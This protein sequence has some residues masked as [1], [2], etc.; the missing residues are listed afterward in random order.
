MERR[1]EGRGEARAGL[2][3]LGLIMQL[4]G[5]IM[6]A[7]LITRALEPLL[8]R[9]FERGGSIH[10]GDLFRRSYYLE[11]RVRGRGEPWPPAWHLTLLASIAILRALLHRRAGGAIL[12]RHRGAFAALCTYLAV[13]FLHT[14]LCLAV[15]HQDM[16]GPTYQWS[17]VVLVG[18]AWPICLLVAATRPGFRRA[19]RG[20]PA[21]SD[22]TA[23]DEVATL[24]IFLG[25]VGAMVG[26][27]AVY[28][29]IETFGGYRYFA[30]GS[31]WP[32]TIGSTAVVVIAVLLL[33][34]A[35]VQLGT[36]FRVAGR[37]AGPDEALAT[38]I[39]VRVGL[40]ASVLAG[41]ALVVHL[42][43]VLQPSHQWY[44]GHRWT[45]EHRFDSS[46]LADH[47][48]IAYLLVL[49]PLLLLRFLKARKTEPATRVTTDPSGASLAALGWFLLAVGA[50]QIALA[51][52]AL[53]APSRDTSLA[54]HWANQIDVSIAVGA[55]SPWLHLL[56]ATPQL[57]TAFE[58]LGGTTR[59]RAAATAYAACATLATVLSIW[60]D[61]SSIMRIINAGLGYP[62]ILAMYF[63]AAFPLLI[64]IVTLVFVQHH[65]RKARP[66]QT[67]TQP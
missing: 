67:V 24:T 17:L 44:S 27:F 2:V 10:F 51:V 45:F 48:L 18:A 29:A 3:S 63:Q 22:D 5:S 42:S 36:G 23:P 13:A 46:S 40:I 56:V 7:Y 11:E 19:L 26:L 57:W 38:R 55:R 31:S 21:A 8:L 34:R 37:P 52:L 25:L 30:S 58:L 65:L 33:V 49:W 32:T 4:V 62:T 39:Y 61:L 54:W 53:V 20:G 59:R 15:L 60:G 41:V 35:V 14:G 43:G 9:V 28:S 64:P 6:A 50:L 47:A 16:T 66:V 12:Y 1:A